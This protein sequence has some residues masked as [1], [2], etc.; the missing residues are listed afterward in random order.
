MRVEKI[1][2]WDV[3]FDNSNKISVDYYPIS[4]K[5]CWIDLDSVLSDAGEYDFNERNFRIIPVSTYGKVTGFYFGDYTKTIFVPCYSD[6][7]FSEL[8]VCYYDIAN[9]GYLDG[10]IILKNIVTK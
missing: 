4:D 8:A 5:S 6:K 2:G 9:K 3:V 10:K 7:P 1:V